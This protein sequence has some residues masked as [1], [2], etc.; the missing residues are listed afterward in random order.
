MSNVKPTVGAAIKAINP[1][2][3]FSTPNDTSKLDNI[4]WF[5]NT[6]PIAKEDIITKYN[7]LVTAWESS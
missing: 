1:N 3:E 4:I 2:A 5:N 7:E 6:T